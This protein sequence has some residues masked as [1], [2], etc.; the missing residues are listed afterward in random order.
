MSP[1]TPAARSPARFRPNIY[2]ETP[3]A[4]LENEYECWRWYAAEIAADQGCAERPWDY[5]EASLR[6]VEEERIGPGRRE[7]DRRRRVGTVPGAPPF[8]APREDRRRALDAI[9]ARVRVE[10]VVERFTAE[11]LRPVGDELLCRCPLPFHDDGSPSFYVH[12]EKQVFHC[13]G[14]GSGGDVFTL[15]MLLLELDGFAAAADVLAVFVGL[16][17]FTRPAAVATPGGPVPIRGGGRRRE[18]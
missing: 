18:R 3:T 9:K 8:P 5:A 7:L 17:L 2:R 15:V 13:F 11:T 1:P 12:P 14:C 16:P 6:W 4:A 10:E